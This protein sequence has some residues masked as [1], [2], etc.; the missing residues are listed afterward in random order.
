MRHEH[1][2][3][4]REWSER[5]HELVVNYLKGFARIVGG[6]T[7]GVVYYVD[8]FAGPGIYGDGAQGSPVRAAEYA[9]TLVGRHYQL[10]CINVEA[11]QQCFSNLEKNTAAYGTLVT[12]H[13]GTFAD[14]VDE[15][16]EGVG[17]RPTIFFLDPFGLKGIGWRY[18]E[19]ILRRPHI[20]EILMRINPQDIARLA[21]FADS[22]AQ[23]AAGKRQ[24]LTDLYGFTDS[25][26][27]VQVWRGAGT[28]G[29]VELYLERLRD[30]MD[31]DRAGSYVYRYAIKTIGGRLKYYLV[32]A[33]RHP[34][35]AILMSNI[36]W[37]RERC[38][39]SDVKEYEERQL[40]LQA[41]RQLSMF[42]V[43]CPPPTEEELAADVASRLKEDIWGAFE[44]KV[45]T[46]IDIH[47]AMLPTWFGRIRG[48]DLTRA[49]K[50]L[51]E[52]GRI[53]HRFGA[54]SNDSTGFTF[55]A[56]Q[57]NGASVP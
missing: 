30:A 52:E 21:G 42:H 53:P 16:L 9:Q 43:L 27:W 12:N 48:K 54:R 14:H 23:G 26:R 1:F 38:Y 11:D 29:L 7:R 46:R 45:A 32:F 6:S 25:G 28:D 56:G 13:C 41:V 20:T 5:K 2:K 51:E 17:D 57:A 33:T 39:E 34:K 44:G 19:P 3:E 10:R 55:Q 4:V 8:G 49:L 40:E 35:G 31:R 22:E 18:L 47:E 15:I 37:G 24:I 50:E 36:I